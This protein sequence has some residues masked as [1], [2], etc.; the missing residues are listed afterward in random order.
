[1]LKA[2]PDPSCRSYIIDRLGPL[3]CH[4]DVLLERL[5]E[6]DEDVPR[7][8]AVGIGRVRRGPPPGG[9]ARRGG[10]TDRPAPPHRLQRGSPRGRRV[11]ARSV[12]AATRGRQPEDGD[13]GRRW[14]INAAGITMVRIDGPVTFLMGALPGQPG[15]DEAEKQHRATIDHSYDIGMTEVTVG[16]FRRFLL[17]RA[18][19]ENRALVPEKPGVLAD[20]PVAGVSWYD[21]AAFCNWLSEKEGLP[22]DQWCYEP[23][24]T[25]SSPRR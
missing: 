10:S 6:A 21:A 24:A 9:Q 2:S 16:Q 25:A 15:W 22:P 17:E 12:G 23:A 4:P 19:R 1:M 8:P 3:G 5:T 20:A 18:A 11:A 13:P 7:R 14:N